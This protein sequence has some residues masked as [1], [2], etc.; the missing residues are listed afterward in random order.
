MLSDTQI[1]MQVWAEQ[2]EEIRRQSLQFMWWWND[3]LEANPN[4]PEKIQEQ[5]WLVLHEM[6]K[7]EHII[8]PSRDDFGR[9]C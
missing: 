5:V 3:Y 6:H 9:L 8:D 4:V 1:M 7:F 2:A